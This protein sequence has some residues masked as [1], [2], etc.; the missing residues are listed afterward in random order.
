MPDICHCIKCDKPTKHI[1]IT[2]ITLLVI[3]AV[4][5]F[6][7][8]KALFWAALPDR[9]CDIV[10]SDAV[11]NAKSFFIKL[12]INDIPSENEWSSYLI[13][14]D[15]NISKVF[16]DQYF[17]PVFYVQSSVDNSEL[18]IGYGCNSNE[19]VSLQIGSGNLG[20]VNGASDEPIESVVYTVRKRL[21]EILPLPLGYRYEGVYKSINGLQILYSRVFNDIPYLNDVIR[22]G[23]EMANNSEEYTI[24]YFKEPMGTVPEFNDILPVEQAA[25]M[26]DSYVTNIPDYIIS[27][28]PQFTI[29][30]EVKRM[31]DETRLAIVESCRFMNSP[32]EQQ[33]VYRSNKANI[34][35]VFY[36]EQLVNVNNRKSL[37]E[38]AVDASDGSL[39]CYTYGLENGYF[40]E[41]GKHNFIF[42]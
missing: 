34:A 33:Y 26:A 12:G 27:Y 4:I 7:G 29:T 6:I 25:E 9:S 24:Y 2:S 11:N 39:V 10:I 13:E 22:V 31:D 15:R 28:V 19:I 16:G 14:R 36:Y 1:L 32:F 35:W 20:V 5:F 30:H 40:P 23:V 18:S 37:A 21:E 3:V 42:K 8:K 17:E 38:V 41:H